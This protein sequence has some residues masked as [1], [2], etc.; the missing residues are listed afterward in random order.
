MNPGEFHLTKPAARAVCCD[1]TQWAKEFCQAKTSEDYAA[2]YD[3]PPIEQMKLADLYRA[4]VQY[5][6]VVVGQSVREIE[7]FAIPFG[8]VAS[9]DRERWSS[10]SDLTPY[11]LRRFAEEGL[12]EKG[13]VGA[14][15]LNSVVMH[16][17]LASLSHA[18]LRSL[19]QEV[20][21]RGVTPGKGGFK[22]NSVLEEIQQGVESNPYDEDGQQFIVGYILGCRFKQAGHQAKPLASSA[23]MWPDLRGLVGG[24]FADDSTGLDTCFVG[25]PMPVYEALETGT[26]YR[27][28]HV[29][30]YM[31]KM[32]H[33]DDA[34]VKV[35]LD[36][37]S[38]PAVADRIRI[39]VADGEGGITRSE[40]IL[41]MMKLEVGSIAK[42]LQAALDATSQ[43]VIQFGPSARLLS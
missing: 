11:L 42:A 37:A 27:V 23:C 8:V 9:T 15:M 28:R 31:R 41:S 18:Q 34:S 22:G 30:E 13:R 21:L 36:S 39:V 35:V 33:S 40:A 1:A 17:D 7:F 43:T 4:T 24:H 3:R 5:Q 25:H 19:A 14:V 6:V 2:L 20:F 12:I 29:A 32:A 16:E 10:V 26:C 38:D